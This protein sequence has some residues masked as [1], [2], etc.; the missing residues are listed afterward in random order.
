ML[1]GIKK[2]GV[3]CYVG[4]YEEECVDSLTYSLG[5]QIWKRTARRPGDVSADVLQQNRK[6][7][8]AHTAEQII[9]RINQRESGWRV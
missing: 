9:R 4:L 8:R 3:G 6:Q 2:K 5:V 7:Q 1:W